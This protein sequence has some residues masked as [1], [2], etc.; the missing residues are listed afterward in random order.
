MIAAFSVGKE[1]TTGSDESDKISTPILHSTPSRKPFSSLKGSENKN[2]LSSGPKRV[3]LKQ[4]DPSKQSLSTP[5]KVLKDGSTPSR[6]NYMQA[7]ESSKSLMPSPQREP[8]SK[9]PFSV[10]DSKQSSMARTP[11]RPSII[12]AAVKPSP[13]SNRKSPGS[14]LRSSPIKTSRLNLQ[15]APTSPNK[16]Q[17][18]TIDRIKPGKLNLK[19]NEASGSPRQGGSTGG[20][21][22]VVVS[23]TRTTRTG[24]ASSSSSSTRITSRTNTNPSARP[25]S[26]TSTAAFGLKRATSSSRQTVSRSGNAVT[27]SKVPTSSSVSTRYRPTAVSGNANANA[28]STTS[29]KRSATATSGRTTASLSKQAAPISSSSSKLSS[30]PTMKPSNAVGLQQRLTRDFNYPVTE[31]SMVSESIDKLVPRIPPVR[32]PAPTPASMPT[33]QNSDCLENGVGEQ[34]V[35]SGQPTSNHN[36]TEDCSLQSLS[37]DMNLIP[38]MSFS[39]DVS[40]VVFEPESRSQSIDYSLGDIIRDEKGLACEKSIANLSKNDLSAITVDFD[41]SASNSMELLT[42]SFI[43]QGTSFDVIS[44]PFTDSHPSFD[45]VCE[46]GARDSITTMSILHSTMG[47]MPSCWTD[48]ENLASDGHSSHKSFSAVV[49]QSTESLPKSIQSAQDSIQTDDTLNL[50]MLEDISLYDENGEN[51]DPA[52]SI[53]TGSTI[54]SIGISIDPSRSISSSQACT[55][56]GSTP[57]EALSELNVATLDFSHTQSMSNASDVNSSVLSIQ[58]CTTSSDSSMANI[59]WSGLNGSTD[60]D[61]S[62]SRGCMDPVACHLNGEYIDL[63]LAID[64]FQP[65]LA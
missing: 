47:S 38:N 34:I 51:F 21:G 29:T 50:G 60:L 25:A 32:T 55:D 26:A 40:S 52:N 42:P 2:S 18:L 63:K 20:G 64:Q 19:L 43:S 7:T 27:K 30:S 57:R 12:S 65:I 39:S 3:L 61:T 53:A 37:F 62:L 48:L 1:N 54:C 35:V 24:A 33:R 23:C 31:P 49:L 28:T 56:S 4:S 41:I 59:D 11:T 44:P 13:Q 15:P 36:S 10:N 5:G 6:Y 9:Q 8:K 17:Q 14:T 16:Q 45:R 46:D 58:S 22:A